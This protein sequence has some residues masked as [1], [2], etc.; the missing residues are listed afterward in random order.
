MTVRAPAPAAAAEAPSISVVVPH[1]DDHAALAGCLA[2]L[3]AQRA[4]GVAFEVIVVDN[5][6]RKMPTAVCAAHGVRR[7]IAPA[8]RNENAP[9]TVMLLRRP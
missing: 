5:G 7:G 9:R 4:G 6:S 2:A 3:A 1:F 8:R